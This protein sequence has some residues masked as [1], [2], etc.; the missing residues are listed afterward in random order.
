MS[1]T[2]PLESKTSSGV[3]LT[4][5]TNLRN[6]SQIRDNLK[7]GTLNCCAIRPDMIYDVFQVIV[8]ANKAALCEK[9]T[10]KSIHSEILYNLSYSKNITQSFQK[11]GLQENGKSVL[12]ATVVGDDDVLDGIEGDVV[13]LGELR[14][15]CNMD[16]LKKAYKLNNCEV[17]VLSSIVSR[18]ACKDLIL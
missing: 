4:L 3:T 9:L 17:D 6:T 8:A 16:A 12:I 13:D 18:I 11:F 7:N 2:F 1:Q 10:T 15:F 5:Y 14:S